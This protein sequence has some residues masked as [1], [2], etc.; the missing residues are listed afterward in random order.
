MRVQQGI[1]KVPNG[2]EVTPLRSYQTLR[3]W[4]PTDTPLA[5]PCSYG[6]DSIHLIWFDTDSSCA[7]GTSEFSHPLYRLRNSLHF[8]S[9][10]TTTPPLSRTVDNSTSHR[11]RNQDITLPPPPLS[12][13]FSVTPRTVSQEARQFPGDTPSTGHDIQGHSVSVRLVSEVPAEVVSQHSHKRT[14]PRTYS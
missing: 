14:Q 7:I 13:V 8:D 5:L 1:S 12:A 9:Y 4:Y 3:F 11:D 2:K 10:A 6:L